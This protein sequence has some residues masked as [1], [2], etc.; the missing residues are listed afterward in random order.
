VQNWCE[1]TE[2]AYLQPG[3]PMR[4][5]HIESS[6]GKLRD[7]CLHAERSTSLKQGRQIMEGDRGDYKTARPRSASDYLTPAVFAEAARVVEPPSTRRVRRPMARRKAA[8]RRRAL[9]LP[10]ADRRSKKDK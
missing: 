3:K 8:F 10:R 4:N 6:N 9:A 1:E 7:E 5:G 2:L